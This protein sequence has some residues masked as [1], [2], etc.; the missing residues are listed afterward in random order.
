MYYTALQ[1]A[2]YVITKC[3]YENHAITNLQLQ[4][5]LYYLQKEFLK[6]D[7]QLFSD[8]FVAWQFGPVIE[9]VYFEYCG[10]GARPIH[11]IY[12]VI[13]SLKHRRMIDTIIEKKRS[14]PPWNLVEETHKPGGAWEIAY[15]KGCGTKISKE[16][17]RE[18]G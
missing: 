18:K 14:L 9:E 17:I 3:T 4:K 7:E 16:L 6:R 10:F 11:R 1:I 8:D 12:N 13:V 5:I 2:E 15:N